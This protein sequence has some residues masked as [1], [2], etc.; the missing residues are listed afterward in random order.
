MNP[1]LCVHLPSFPW[2]ESAVMELLV[3]VHHLVD[4]FPAHGRHYLLPQLL[5]AA[6]IFEFPHMVHFKISP[7][8]PTVF[9]LLGLKPLCDFGSGEGEVQD[10]WCDI[11]G[12]PIDSKSLEIFE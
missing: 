5:L 3:A 9:T 2:G 6:N 1:A 11:R 10:A 4:R 12:L 7:F 8:L